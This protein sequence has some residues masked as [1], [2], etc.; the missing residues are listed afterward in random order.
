MY[1]LKNTRMNPEK[2]KASVP[3]KGERPLYDRVYQTLKER[4]VSGELRAGET[5]GEVQLAEQLEVSRTPVRDA[6]RR[7]VDAGLLVAE[8]GG[9]RVYSPTAADLADVYC[10]RASLEGMAARLAALHA[11][12]SFAAELEDICNAGA[13]IVDTNALHAA[14]MLNGQFHD[15]ILEKS[16]NK[17]IK[18]LL[19]NLSPVI[20]RYRHISLSFEDH[21]KTSWAEHKE[22]VQLFRECNP[23]TVEDHVKNHIL[24]AG[25]RIVSTL[26]SVEGDREIT[27][28][29][30]L[31]LSVL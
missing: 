10:T 16:G 14:A 11:D 29:M 31:V 21:L 23:S 28:A 3:L 22:I 12:E 7:L 8:K 25:G 15:L 30:E 5:I 17:R 1:T 24:R 20:V 27:P 26:Q 9:V 4:I 18:H 6:V 2:N 19:A 13:R